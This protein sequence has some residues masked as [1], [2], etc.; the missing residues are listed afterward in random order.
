[1][2]VAKLLSVCV[3][4]PG[5]AWTAQAGGTLAFR[6]V[7]AEAGLNVTHS[8]GPLQ[9]IAGGAVGDFNNDGW[10]DIFML[11]GPNAP[12][13]LFINNGDG[14]FSDRAAAWGVAAVQRGVGACVG[15]YNRDGWL[16]I[17]VTSHGI[18]SREP[19]H[20]RL[21]RNNGDGT[22][23]DVAAEAGVQFTSPTL[24]DG[25]GAAFGDYDLDG[26]LDLAV[27]AW[28][29]GTNVLFRNS[30]DGSFA[31]VT[32]TAILADMTRVYGFSPRFV[33]M[34]GDRYP[35]L[36][37]VSD[38]FTS[39]YL[40]NNRDG[41]FRNAT[42]EAGVGL[43][44]NGMG[45]T[46]GD[47]NNDGRFDYYVTSID[48][49]SGNVLYINQ[50]GHRYT[51]IGR[52]A[53]VSW[54]GFAWGTFAGDLD[55]DGL[56]DL[57]VT[58]GVR[59]GPWMFDATRVYHNDGNL[60]FT[61]IAAAVGVTHTGQGRGLA[62]FDYD[63]DGDQDFVI[64]SFA[65]PLE[66]YRNELS[67]SGT[68]WLRVFLDTSQRPDLA[69]NG[70]GARVSVTAAGQSR[71]RV[72]DG[73]CNYL[74]QSELSAHFG[75]GAAEQVE[76]L[77]VAWPNGKQ[78]V[79]RHLPANQALTV[80]AKLDGDLDQDGDV[81][82]TDLA[83][84]LSAFLTCAGDPYYDARADITPDGCVNMDDLTSLLLDFGLTR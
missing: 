6:Q 38:F 59:S 45:A 19:G 13:A 60:R 11:M 31:D 32:T 39:R 66:L 46:V 63:N 62:N 3:L 48:V 50:G 4:A 44:S 55:H 17:Y 9:Y 42:R 41:T 8:G 29:T 24:V 40:V 52:D 18:D 71:H 54:A 36:L 37:W 72:I 70:F 76:E 15:D 53:G 68:N 73:G 1:M 80:R 22:F 26:D 34:D 77:R 81:D 64:F 67:G 83:V 75:L 33:D 82:L 21:Y 20:H 25:Y 5:L 61:D 84:M 2:V 16:D 58:N 43:E 51:E 57:V 49:V 65:E 28:S 35:E 7:A 23:S 14:T 74:S 27:A 10:Q 78:T 12:D 69:P 30:G 79:L 56:T 47:F